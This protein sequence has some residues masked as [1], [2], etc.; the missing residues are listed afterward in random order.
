[1][2]PS[3]YRK[4]MARLTGGIFLSGI[5][6]VAGQGRAL[7]NH[8]GKFAERAASRKETCL[9]ETE[10]TEATKMFVVGEGEKLQNRDNI[11]RTG[12]PT[13]MSDWQEI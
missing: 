12:K 9:S 5:S 10:M 2:V 8:S 11:N 7:M 13:E 3:L 6:T 1:M 4:E